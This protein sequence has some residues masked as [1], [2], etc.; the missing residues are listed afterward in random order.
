MTHALSTDGKNPHMWLLQQRE[1]I[2]YRQSL[3]PD[4]DCDE[5]L[6]RPYNYISDGKVNELLVMYVND[7]IMAHMFDEEHSMLSIPFYRTLQ[8]CKKIDW[9]KVDQR[10]LVHMRNLALNI[11]LSKSNIKELLM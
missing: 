2:N 10:H 7:T 6:E 8:I 1:R 9:I 11:G 4:P 5:A 3:F